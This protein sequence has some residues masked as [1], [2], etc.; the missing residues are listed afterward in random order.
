MTEL[1]NFYEANM[2]LL[3]KH[4]PNIWAIIDSDSCE[5]MGEIF[6]SPNG[7]PNIKI[8]T[9][10]G[11]EV[12]LHDLNQP[13]VEVREFLNSV[14]EESTGVVVL[15][16][17]GLGYILIAFLQQRPK[18]R[19]VAVFDLEPG[20][21]KQALQVMDFSTVLTDRRLILS[22][23]S[24]P[25]VVSVLAP[26]NK[27]L[28]LELI[29]KLQ[30]LLSFRYNE[31][32]YQ[33]L[34]KEVFKVINDINMVGSTNQ[35]FGKMFINNRLSLLN[36]IHHNFLLEDLQGC[37]AGIPAILVA[38]GPSLDKNIH[39]LP[40]IK[41]KAIIIG[42]DTVLPALLAQ[43]V[44][45]HFITSIDP[46]KLTY[47]KIADSADQIKD[48]SLIAAPH[49]TPEVHKIFPASNIFWTFSMKSIESWINSM[50]EG[51]ILTSGSSTCAHLNLT[52]AIMMGC[53]PIIYIGQDLAFSE[54][55]DY[56]AGVVLS[57]P[58]LVKKKLGATNQ[59]T[60]WLDGVNGG[61]VP[62]IRGFLGLK[63][64]FEYVM[65]NNLGPHYINAT[66]GGAHIAGTEV[67]PLQEVIDRYCSKTIE[68]PGRLHTALQDS[69]PSNT[70]KLLSGLNKAL[71][72]AKSLSKT[73]N[74][75][76]KLIHSILH[77]IR[78]ENNSRAAGSVADLP[79]VLQNK[80][81]NVEALE[82]K[83]DNTKHMYI[84]QILG[85]GTM[86]DVKKSE[87]S[88][89]EI[90]TLARQSENFILSFTKNLERLLSLNKARK[91]ILA[92]FQHRLLHIVDFHRKEKKILNKIEQKKNVEQNL[93]EL[94]QF[95]FE[96]GNFVL[97]QP[98]LEKLLA[99][100]PDS[101]K[102]LFYSGAIAARQSKF[103]ESEEYFQ[104][105]QEADTAMSKRVLEFRQE[106]GDI[107]FDLAGTQGDK[108]YSNISRKMLFKGI[109]YCSDHLKIKQEIIY[110]A[111]SDLTKIKSALES[112]TINDV[113]TILTVWHKGLEEN[114]N[115]APCITDDKIAGFHRHYGDL[116]L[117]KEDLD[118]ALKS[119]QAALKF[120]PDNPDLYATAAELF[121]A[122][123][124]FT[125][126][127]T[128][129]NKAVE[130]DRSYAVLWENMGDHLHQTGEI[131]DAIAAYE[132]GFIAIPE[133][134]NLLKKIGDC[135]LENGQLEA[136][137]EAYKMV[138]E[139]YDLAQPPRT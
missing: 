7:Q 54:Y 112:G 73:V 14:P 83:M 93:F 128:H 4:H 40:K 19:H 61:K 35:K 16:G 62:S 102:V 39:L 113:E 9:K 126:G 96:S 110:L 18:I 21:F 17:M 25:N 43:G 89:H 70:K 137:R 60:I 119:M 50:L 111:E 12:T 131:N 95:Y 31:S 64:H 98:V 78:S 105:A 134:I 24:H 136:A 91:N 130:L 86:E 6:L 58:D 77:Y 49:V 106:L 122:M 52:A 76:D 59:N 97:A 32:G 103:E 38:G 99:L 72:N 46:Q 30:H 51:K 75:H 66:E 20:I 67:L 104:K 28:Q 84:W 108:I 94:V 88:L 55:R 138:K 139:K 85:E 27:A 71:N 2:G 53:S 125:N 115:L 5:P 15:I 8:V 81:S 133:N 29:H 116:L 107:Y 135:Y 1:P 13:E 114:K 129:L 123:Q 109:R 56:A 3:K 124:D 42:V 68:F 118:G 87:R 23:G 37:F 11:N 120:T 80:I 127:I 65:A 74:K 121:F 132:Q 117:T 63:N 92:M 48:V 69:N 82:K 90:T 10:E 36:S 45:P 34:D 44:S 79:V 26:A 101:P 33:E 47:E 57:D 22:L 100:N 41:D